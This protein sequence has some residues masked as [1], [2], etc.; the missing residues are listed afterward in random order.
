VDDSVG[1]ICEKLLAKVQISGLW[2]NQFISY[3]SVSHINTRYNWSQQ[4]DP[5]QVGQGVS[6]D[7]GSPNPLGLNEQLHKNLSNNLS[8]LLLVLYILQHDKTKFVNDK[9][10]NRVRTLHLAELSLLLRILCSQIALS[11][12]QSKHIQ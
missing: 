6:K 4:R 2:K 12:F 10:L 1:H 3:C 7:W 5:A 9:V 11:L 8:K